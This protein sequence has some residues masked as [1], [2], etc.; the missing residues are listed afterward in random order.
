MKPAGQVSRGNIN[1]INE[2]MNLMLKQ[3]TSLAWHVYVSHYSVNIIKI[4]THFSISRSTSCHLKSIW[5]GPCRLLPLHPTVASLC[6]DTVSVV[7]PTQQ[8]S[9]VIGLHRARGSSEVLGAV[10]WSSRLK[11]LKCGPLDL[12]IVTSK[13]LYTQ[14]V[15]GEY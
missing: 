14:S 9:K 1:I 3:M 8:L 12:I 13:Q 10:G 2:I 5:R 7:H 15:S 6:P 4:L 11:I